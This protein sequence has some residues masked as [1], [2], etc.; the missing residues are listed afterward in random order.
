MFRRPIGRGEEG[1]CQGHAVRRGVA[2]G[3]VGDDCV[4]AAPTRATDLAGLPP[5]FIECCS[6]EVFRDEDVA[7]ASGLWAAGS[8]AELP[9]WPGG[10]HGCDQLA[11]TPG[12]PRT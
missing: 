4:L 9:V 1:Q 6:A 12:S 5:A 7:Y 3:R 2:S 8:Q 10:F 11:P